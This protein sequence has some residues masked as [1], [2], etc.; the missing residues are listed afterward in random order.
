MALT[1]GGAMEW[2]RHEEFENSA[3][4]AGM[5]IGGMDAS[6]TDFLTGGLSAEEV[7]RAARGLCLC[8]SLWRRVGGCRLCR[9]G[10]AHADGEDL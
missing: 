8:L 4:A 1:R 5:D 10:A 6:L 9:G 7:G 3:R 2:Q